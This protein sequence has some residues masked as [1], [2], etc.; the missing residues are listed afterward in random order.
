MAYLILLLLFNLKMNEVMKK[1]ASRFNELMQSIRKWFKRPKKKDDDD[2]F[3]HPY[4][5]Y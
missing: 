3:D 5:I 2:W 4:A 1:V